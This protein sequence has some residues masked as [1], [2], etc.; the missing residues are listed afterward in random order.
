ML[1]GTAPTERAR[2][3]EKLFGQRT[4]VAPHD[5]QPAPGGLAVDRA[6]DYANDERTDGLAKRVDGPVTTSTRKSG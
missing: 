6:T 1:W 3:D 5:V 2:E 4:G